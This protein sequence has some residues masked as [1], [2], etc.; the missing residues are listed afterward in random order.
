L[1][2]VLADLSSAINRF[3]AAVPFLHLLVLQRQ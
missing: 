3:S 2:G 1:N